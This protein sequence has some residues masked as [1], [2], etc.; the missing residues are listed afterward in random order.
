M[1]RVELLLYLTLLG[2]SASHAPTI[3]A[4]S[5]S[6][7]I[8]TRKQRLLVV[9]V[10][11]RDAISQSRV[12]GVKQVW[13]GM[14]RELV[15][16]SLRCLLVF[17]GHS[18]T[19]SSPSSSEFAYTADAACPEVALNTP[20]GYVDLG[21]KVKSMIEY[22]AK[23]THEA[24]HFD[25]L[26][27]TD[28]DTLICFSM[29]TDMIDAVRR[30]FHTDDQ[31]YLGHVETCSKIEHFQKARFY[32]PFYMEDILHKDDAPCYPP[33][34]QGLGYVLSKDLV[35]ML[36]SIS[37]TLKVYTN[38][39]MMVG[40]WLVGHK[41]HRARLVARQFSETLYQT[42]L[43]ECFPLYFN[44]KVP[45][46]VMAECAHFHQT[47]GLCWQPRQQ[48]AL[49]APGGGGGTS[50]ARADAVPSALNSHLASVTTG[51]AD[52]D[53]PSAD[54]LTRLR[55]LVSVGIKAVSHLRNHIHFILHSIHRRYPGLRVIVADDEYIGVAREEW[56]RLTDLMNDLNVTCAPP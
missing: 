47:T 41:V 1:A 45:T 26:L 28:V 54:S 9:Y 6:S 32:D 11:G 46:F 7:P 44:H 10:A 38:E 5:S 24:E 20:D 40:T 39:D 37:S 19:G 21:H 50:A 3:A 30:R 13:N 27:K 14:Q 49:P 33:Y 55:A 18:K 36:A 53:A 4:P 23:Q 22:V 16:W 42:T 52:V 8:S 2:A 12:K 15:G 25:F 31:I 56:R 29:V 43:A 35:V 17:G 51:A 34:M 48:D